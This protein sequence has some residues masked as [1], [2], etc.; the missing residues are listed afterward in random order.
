MKITTTGRDTLKSYFVK[1][2][3]PTQANFEDLIAAGL[4]QRDDGLAKPAGEPLSLQAEGDDASQKKALNL[5]RDFNDAKPAWTLA[6]SPRSDPRNAQTGRNGLGVT[7]GDGVPRLFIDQATGNLGVGTVTPAVKLEVAG[8]LRLSGDFANNTDPV[9]RMSGSGQLQIRGNAPQIDFLDTDHKQ[10]SIHVNSDKLYFIREPWNHNDLVLDGAGRVGIGCNDPRAKLEVRDGAIMPSFGNGEQFGLFFPADAA[11]GSGDR[12]WL[13]YYARRG[14]ATTL[15][16]GIANDGDDHLLLTTSGGVGINTAEPAGRLH[17][18]TGGAGAWDR[19][20]VNTTSLWGDGGTQYVT[21]GAGGAEGIMLHNPHVVWMPSQ[22][23]AS[24]RMGRSGG[25]PGGHWWD[26]GVRAG[27]DFSIYDGHNGMF[28]LSIT[29]SGVVRVN[30]LQL[31]GKWRFSGVGDAHG[32]DEWLRM[33]N[34]AGSGYHGGLAAGKFWSAGNYER[35]DAASKRDITPLAD[36]LDAVRRLTGVRWRWKDAD[37]AAAPGLGLIAQQVEQV[38]PEAVATGPE[39]LKG[40]NY[41]A[42]V[43]PLVEAVKAQQAQI[44]ALAAELQ[45]LRAALAAR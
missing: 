38:F 10:W 25:V 5:Y 18:Q 41:G 45:A 30:I 27:N 12:A 35:S 31:G 11:G 26:I 29:E 28:G 36:A 7:D 9:S 15:E 2:A 43:A 32:N 37:D 4:N 40:V 3:V 13:R 17:V 6:L 16:L 20:V 23:R 44:E 33:F 24:I 8:A 21:I 19:F 22:Q 34:T 14:E 1:N 39:G 42:L